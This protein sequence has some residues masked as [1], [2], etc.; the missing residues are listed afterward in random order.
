VKPVFETYSDTLLD[1]LEDVHGKIERGRFKYADQTHDDW[2][3]GK[4]AQSVQAVLP[5]LVDAWNPMRKCAT[6]TASRDIDT[7]EPRRS[8]P[9]SSSPCTTTTSAR[10]ARHRR[11]PGAP[12]ARARGQACVTCRQKKGGTTMRYQLDFSQVL[13]DF[14]GREIRAGVPGELAQALRRIHGRH[15]GRAASSS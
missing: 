14:D 10:S 7:V 9:S 3:Y 13:T 2:N 12:R 11:A 5:E 6:R 1:E 8:K 4:S 15:G